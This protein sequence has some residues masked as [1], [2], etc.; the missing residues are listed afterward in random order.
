MSSTLSRCHAV[1]RG[2]EMLKWDWASFLLITE[3][4]KTV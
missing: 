1:T 3:T 2:H 4:I